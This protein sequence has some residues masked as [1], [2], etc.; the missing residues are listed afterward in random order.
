MAQSLIYNGVLAAS[1]FVGVGAAFGIFV[2]RRMLDAAILLCASLA[3]FFHHLASN[4]RGLP[5]VIWIEYDPLLLNI[6][7][8]FAAVAI[9]RVLYM[10]YI[11]GFKAFWG[12][13]LLAGIALFCLFY[14][15]IIRRHNTTEV[16]KILH[17]VTHC[18]W[19]VLAYY[20]FTQFVA[21]T[22]YLL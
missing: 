3:S 1:N 9:S 14:S 4:R 2:E 21:H 19:H 15:D 10:W 7:R 13:L 16:E 5:G 8:V 6:D 11:L 17:T 12:D 20:L 18:T 22:R